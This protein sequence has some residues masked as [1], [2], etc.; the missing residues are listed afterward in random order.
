VKKSKHVW[1]LVGFVLGTIF[2][3]RVYAAIRK[4]A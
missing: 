2:G 3:G 4:I 1:G